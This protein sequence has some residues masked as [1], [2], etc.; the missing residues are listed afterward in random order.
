[1]YTFQN[2]N[3]TQFITHNLQIMYN[4]ECVIS[5]IEKL[6]KGKENMRNKR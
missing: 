6:R 4:S 1:M 2:L 5:K 3:F